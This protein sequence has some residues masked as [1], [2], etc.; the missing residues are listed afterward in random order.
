[1]LSLLKA[2]K[3]EKNRRFGHFCCAKGK[4]DQGLDAPV[5]IR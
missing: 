4:K 5:E 2:G 1:L 3:E